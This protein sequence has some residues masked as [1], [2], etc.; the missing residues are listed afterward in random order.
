MQEHVNQS[1]QFDVYLKIFYKL[2]HQDTCHLNLDPNIQFTLVCYLF[3]YRYN[4]SPVKHS[5]WIV[6]WGSEN[7]FEIKNIFL[8]F[9]LN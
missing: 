3:V 6:H 7:I 4:R 1:T 2:V 8:I 9:F 5:T